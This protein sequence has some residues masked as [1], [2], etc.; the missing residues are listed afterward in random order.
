MST[1]LRVGPPG[2]DT[3]LRVATRIGQLAQ[4]VAAQNPWWRG[5]DW[6]RRDRELTQ[7]AQSGLNYHSGALGDLQQGCLYVLRGP[8]R[9]GKTVAMKQLVVDLLAAGVPPTAVVR[10]AVDGWAAKD[11]RTLTQNAAL[12]RVPPGARRYWLL[13]EITSVTGDWPEQLKWLRDNDPEFGDAT[14]VL[15]GSS[16]ARL[17]EAVGVLAGRRGRGAH[18]DR[19]LLPM[20]FRT[21]AGHVMADLPPSVGRLPLNGLKTA[22][23]ADVYRDLTPW[24]DGLV[25]AWELYLMYGGYPVAVVAAKDGAAV[26]EWFVND[27]FDIVANDVFRTSQL[28]ATVEMALLER[29]WSTITSFAVYSKIGQDLGVSH[30][31]VARHVG[32]LRNAYL[33]WPC[34][35]R[36][37]RSWTPKERAQDKVYAV[38]PLVARLPHLRNRARAD[39]D[40]TALVEMQLGNAVRRRIVSEVPLSLTDHVVFHVRTP[41]R[42]EIDFVSE[43]LGGVALEGKYT[44]GAWRSEAATVDASQ[45][46]GLLATRN[47]LELPSEGTRAWAVP[48]AMLAYLIDV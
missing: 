45:W 36:D 2:T 35:Q 3:I 9:V 27:L 22:A 7:V 4:E 31:V 12:P 29:L 44:E 16:A 41:A 6:E 38:D 34:P 30:E 15:T 39:I 26:P 37:D 24:L 28:P 32:F 13:D 1:F 33:L 17:T 47:V 19:T 23:A 5:P 10:V 14:V 48:A 20:G 43:Y 8:R 18:L 42:K 21:F 11:L 40:T 46:S 25:R